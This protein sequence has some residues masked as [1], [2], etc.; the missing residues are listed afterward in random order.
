LTIEYI[1]LLVCAFCIGLKFMVSAPK[2]A[3]EKAGPKLGARIEKHLATGTGFKDANG[4]VVRWEP[5]VQK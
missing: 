1:L 3:F 4:R 2:Y 5:P